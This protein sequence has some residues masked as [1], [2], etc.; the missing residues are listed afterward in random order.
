MHRTDRGG[1]TYAWG[2]EAD[3]SPA[4]IHK[5]EASRMNLEAVRRNEDV[6][7]AEAEAEAEEEQEEKRQRK[8]R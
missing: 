6:A 5:M 1:R 4:L 7:E 3:R 8:G 2:Q